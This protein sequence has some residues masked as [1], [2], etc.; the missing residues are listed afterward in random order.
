MLKRI[1]IDVG[2][3]TNTLNTKIH[4]TSFRVASPDG[5]RNKLAW[6]KVRCV[7][8]VVS[9]PKFHYNDLLPTSWQLSC[10]RRSYGET[11]VMDFGLICR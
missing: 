1:V 4:Y 8:C 6:A 5:D 7:C 9:F 2:T 11:C 10:L 3:I